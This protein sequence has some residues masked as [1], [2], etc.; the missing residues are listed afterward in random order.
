[1][2]I[3]AGQRLG[4]YEI[5]APLGAGGMGEVWR[6]RDTRLGREVAIKVLPP[7]LAEDGE[8]LRRFEREAR[9][10]AA[11]S[12]PNILA[13]HD[14]G[15]DDGVVYAVTELLYGVT[16]RERLKSGALPWRRAVDWAAQTARGLAAAH[17]KGI[18]H[19][20]VKP[21]NLFLV[22][23]GRVKVLDFG[24]A[25]SESGSGNS[26]AL[27]LEHG[28][29]HAHT[30]PGRVLG[31]VGYM[32]PE[33]LVGE[34]VDARSDVFALGC[35]LFEMLTGATPFHRDSV[36]EAMGAVLREEP[37]PLVGVPDG[38]GQPVSPSLS[39]LV[40]RC[41][42]RRPEERFQ[43]AR[44]LAF[45]LEVLSG[46]TGSRSEA[47]LPAM[48]RSR[49]RGWLWPAIAAGCLVAGALAGWWISRPAP[50]MPSRLHALTYSGSDAWP[51]ASP[52][53]RLLA[54][55]SERDGRS[56]IW[57][58]QTTT[59]DEVALTEGPDTLPRFS[60]DGASVLFVRRREGGGSD[61]WRVA[62]LGG[63]PRRVV[64]D[65]SA[66]DWSPDGSALA[67]VRGG[68]GSP[69]SGWS[70]LTVRPD[71]GGS[72]TVLLTD[73][74]KLDSPRWSPDGRRLAL[75]RSSTIRG[76][77]TIVLVDAASKKRAEVR[78]EG[79]VW[80][81]AWSGNDDLLYALAEGAGARLPS[82]QLV[83]RSGSA[84]RTLM[85]VPYT[86]PSLEVLSAGR[87]VLTTLNR[88]QN[89]REQSLREAGTRDGRGRPLPL[90]GQGDGGIGV[91]SNPRQRW[92]SRGTSVDRQPVY[93][94]DGE[95]VAFAST[96]GGNLDLWAVSTR[97]GAVRRLTDDPGEDW[98]P[99]FA[100]DGRLLWSSNRG[101]HFEVWSA[102]PDGNA[103]RQLS[104]DGFDAENPTAT[105][106]GWVIYAS[107]HPG[108]QGIWKVRA[109]GS[110]ASRLVA[111]AEA[112]HPEASP[113]GRFVLYHARE[114]DAEAI[115]VVRLG[116]GSPVVRA[117]TIALGDPRARRVTDELDISLGR[118]RWRPDGRAILYVGLDEQGRVA[119]FE[120]AFAA[121]AV[122]SSATEA[123]RE[124][125]PR[126]LVASEDEVAVES[127]GV[128]K[129]GT[130]IT[131]SFREQATNLTLAEG[132]PDVAPPRRGTG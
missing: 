99:A 15:T 126:L 70:V 16:L 102:E 49:Q 94:P 116:D 89:L 48:E 81:L 100:P 68:S 7:H 83:L 64:N 121:D 35:V 51:A 1:M 24:L 77:D 97:S 50:A 88:R 84:E 66:G 6:A 118:A 72:E 61:L 124:A 131:V 115:Q 111:N 5:L 21:E 57:L 20:D 117:A 82:S 52:D 74:L 79:V 65:A 98:D 129:D 17:D 47:A 27:N 53:G 109:D 87:V 93:S 85:W 33:Q 132:L 122:S 40:M 25:R 23:D 38:A 26:G 113:D 96:R 105:G 120:R 112:A 30:Q 13:L 95:W 128:S 76:A 106:D 63:E 71:G 73:P 86:V 28:K 36:V 107:S 37:A 55:A 62:T 22:R 69:G 34:P 125:Q 130:R 10:V 119:I 56:S 58:R 114:G 42:E 32:S 12:D 4:P 59:G 75:L 54:F 104:R 43:S 103:P 110:G 123:A 127:F 3:A 108:Q 78:V 18:V 11:L 2:T 41:L 67:L 90:E 8:A 101:G 60:P 31:T 9:T 39:R 44:D 92:L 29:T 19:R 80:S 46:E 14:F 45:A 91:G